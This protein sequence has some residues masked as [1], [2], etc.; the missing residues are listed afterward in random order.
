MDMATLD[1]HAQWGKPL[2][3]V[4]EKNLARLAY[5]PLLTD[6]RPLI[7]HMLARGI[8]LEQEAIAFTLPAGVT[9]K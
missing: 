3:R 1:A 5:H 4:D 2:T 8:K 7:A 9:G 6:M